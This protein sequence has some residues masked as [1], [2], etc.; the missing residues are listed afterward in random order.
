LVQYVDSAISGTVLKSTSGWSSNTG[1]D[2]YGFRVLP[3]GDHGY[4]DALGYIDVSYNIGNYAHFWSS[5]EDDY[6]L[7]ERRN[8]LSDL[9]NADRGNDNK[10]NGFS[11]RCIAN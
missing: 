4:D 1:T 3:A 11:L 2:A 7:A 5:S 10:P 8:F 6:Y 9:A